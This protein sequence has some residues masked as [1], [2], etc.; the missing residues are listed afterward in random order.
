MKIFLYLF[1]LCLLASCSPSKTTGLSKNFDLSYYSK[2]S[3]IQYELKIEVNRKKLSLNYKNKRK[4]LSSNYS[5]DIEDSESEN[6][7]KYLKS[8]NMNSF[9]APASDRLLDVPVQT[10]KVNYDNKS[11]TIDYGTVKDPPIEIINLKNMLFE[12]TSKYN[13]NWKKDLDLQ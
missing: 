2:S 13:K 9:K 3:L 5:Y 10:I 7:Y 8:N 12:L 4:G 6:L 11:N 1:I